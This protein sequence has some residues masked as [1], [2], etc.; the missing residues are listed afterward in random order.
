VVVQAEMEQL[1]KDLLVVLEVQVIVMVVEV[2]VLVK[3]EIQM[4]VHLVEMVYL[5]LSQVLL[6]VEVVVVVDQQDNLV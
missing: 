4:V 1:I 5:P 3:L 2:V 6:L